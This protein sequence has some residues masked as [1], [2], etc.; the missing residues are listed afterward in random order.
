[1]NKIK[2]LNKWL[3]ISTV[4]IIILVSCFVYFLVIHKK[5]TSSNGGKTWGQ[6]GSINY[7]PPTSQEIKDSQ[8]IKENIDNSSQN[9]TNNNSNSDNKR[10]VTPIISYAE[11][12]GKNIEV[13]SYVS[14]VFED[15]GQ[16]S[17]KLTLND[18]VVSRT[19]TG[20]KD[21]T[22]TRCPTV[23]IP[24]TEFTNSGTWNLKVSYESST[25]S[26]VSK[27][28]NIGVTL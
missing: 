27:D 7:G 26:G 3:V 14:G 2:K 20:V 15:G 11:Q 17:I 5:N 21:A 10:K 13:S 22:T 16:C 1:M 9:S 23:S 19:V 6:Q 12:Y 25:S 18:K 28:T 8:N 24:I 4:L